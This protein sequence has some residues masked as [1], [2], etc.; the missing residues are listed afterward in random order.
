[1]VI[2]LV[3]KGTLTFD[4][5]ALLGGLSVTIFGV[6]TSDSATGTQSLSTFLHPFLP[7]TDF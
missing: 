4:L 1:M 6:T 7:L 2:R 5:L 3:T